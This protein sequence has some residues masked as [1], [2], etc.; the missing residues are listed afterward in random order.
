VPYHFGILMRFRI[1]VERASSQDCTAASSV[2]QKEFADV[3]ARIESSLARKEI[4]LGKLPAFYQLP[5]KSV[6]RI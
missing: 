1:Y 5:Y 2:G 3:A 4:Q 6:F